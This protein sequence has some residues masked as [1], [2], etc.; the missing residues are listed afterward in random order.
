MTQKTTFRSEINGIQFDSDNGTTNHL[1]HNPAKTQF[2]KAEKGAKV[3]AG[4]KAKV[5]VPE[6]DNETEI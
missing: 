4:G 6:D 1:L 3:K 5:T 2:V